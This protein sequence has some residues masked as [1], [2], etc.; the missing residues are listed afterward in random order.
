LEEKHKNR[1]K[2]YNLCS[3][4]HYDASRFHN[5]VANYPFDDHHPP[6]FELI[7]PFC[8]DVKSWLDED[9]GNIVAIHCKAGKGR[10]GVMI[11]CFLLD[12]NPDMTAKD[13]LELYD[14]K[15]T[16]D[17]RGV[18]IPSQRRY[19]EYYDCLVRRGLEYQSV[20]LKPM[21]LSFTPLPTLN[22]G[23]FTLQITIYQNNGTSDGINYGKHI[24]K[25]FRSD[26]I[27]VRKNQESNQF[28]FLFPQDC[29][30][31]SG[32]ARI[33]VKCKEVLKTKSTL[34]A[35]WL[36]TFFVGN[37]YYATTSRQS[38]STSSARLSSGNTSLTEAANTTTNHSSPPTNGHCKPVSE[39]HQR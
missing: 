20:I 26:P 12:S 11:C 25:V 10:T 28:S 21:S 36:N 16:R 15:R 19:V 13:A 18:T 9:P 32:D 27:E 29:K 14:K 17:E 38:S 7:K 1:Y 35:F 5:R 31:V 24:S 39:R 8:E 4:R 33:E 2:L 23:S 6:K 30:C 22:G 3:E 37:C 34:F